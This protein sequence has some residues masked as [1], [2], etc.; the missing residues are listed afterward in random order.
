VV[1]VTGPMF[2]HPKAY[3]GVFNY[4][5]IVCLTEYW[6]GLIELQLTKHAFQT[7]PP[8]YT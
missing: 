7:L 1:A 5:F 4:F 2:E 3:L 6:V 8:T